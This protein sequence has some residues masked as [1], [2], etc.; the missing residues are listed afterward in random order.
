MVYKKRFYKRRYY[1]RFKKGTYQRKYYKR[2]YKKSYRKALKRPEVHI[3][4]DNITYA[5]TGDNHNGT[6][7]NL[8][9]I[10][11]VDANGYAQSDEVEYKIGD[12]K[13]EG[14]KIRLKYL[15]IKGYF[16]VSSNLEDDI[17]G[18]IYVFR[19]KQ[20]LSNNE[21]GW[22]GLLDTPY[23]LNDTTNFSNAQVIK[24]LLYVYDWKNDVKTQVK[25]K[26]KS[27]YRKYDDANNVIPFKI[28]IPLYDCVLTCDN[29]YS[30]STGKFSAQSVPS[31]NG[32]WLGFIT[33]ATLS[34]GPDDQYP[35][36]YLQMKYKLYY[37]D[38]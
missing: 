18:K 10:S 26:V 29:N 19:R 24:N 8:T 35:G 4:K 22:N 7:I 20:N 30:I 2:R 1:K 15:Y 12:K 28:R 5:S 36:T 38:Y 23:N 6:L 9:K 13:I 27:L 21:L 16:Q 32:I 25:R 33:T 3:L 14:R 31:T 37:T 34:G 11:N 17:N